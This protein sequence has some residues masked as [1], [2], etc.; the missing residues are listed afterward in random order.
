MYFASQLVIHPVKLAAQVFNLTPRSIIHGYVTVPLSNQ[1]GCSVSLGGWSTDKI[2]DCYL[3]QLI[4]C[5]HSLANLYN[6][7]HT[8]TLQEFNL[9]CFELTKFEHITKRYALHYKCAICLEKLENASTVKNKWLGYKQITD[10]GCCSLAIPLFHTWLMLSLWYLH[11]RRVSSSLFF[12]TCWVFYWGKCC[13]PNQFC[14][15]LQW[16]VVLQ[17]CLLN[18]FRV[19]GGRWRPGIEA[20]YYMSTYLAVKADQRVEDFVLAFVH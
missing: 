3:L 17:Y 5:V 14:S 20:K 19:G 16:S 1:T 8:H 18:T 2:R 9:V 11:M 13:L 12:C 4:W 6:D 10:I 7:T 15:S